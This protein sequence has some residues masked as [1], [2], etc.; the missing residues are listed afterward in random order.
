MSILEQLQ[1]TKNK[2]ESVEQENKVI[3]LEIIEYRKEI[4]NIKQ[5]NKKLLQEN[6]ELCEL[7]DLEQNKSH[8]SHSLS[9]EIELINS[10][11]ADLNVQ[12]S[13]YQTLTKRLNSRY[14]LIQSENEKYKISLQQLTNKQNQMEKIHINEMA[15]LKN[16]IK[17]LQN[18]CDILTDK[19][20]NNNNN[21]Y[22]KCCSLDERC[23]DCNY[24][25]VSEGTVT[26]IKTI[27]SNINTSNV[28]YNEL[29]MQSNNYDNDMI[30]PLFQF[31]HTKSPFSIQTQTLNHLSCNEQINTL[32]RINLINIKKINTLQ[33]RVKHLKSTNIHLKL[34]AEKSQ[35]S[36]GCKW[37][38]WLTFSFDS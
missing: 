35:D 3:K 29:N 20:N 31:K 10:Y 28:L 23:I 22:T 25:S 13:K 2:L 8:H 30:S 14:K 33:K 26:R 32:N 15:K 34:L 19:L 5:E 27:E 21:I 36:P 6:N 12:I 4:N 17:Q 24:V 1:D 38:K 7:I 37:S 18:E 9:A 11:N 16:K